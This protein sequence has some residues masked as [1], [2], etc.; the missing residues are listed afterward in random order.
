[1]LDRIEFLLS[2]AIISLRRNRGMTFASIVASALALVIVGG[3]TLTYV[4]LSKYV[5]EQVSKFEMKVFARQDATPDQVTNL[6]N[7]IKKLEGV[8]GVSFK[9]KAE[10]WAEWKKEEPAITAGL[11]LD[12]PMPDTYTVTFKNLEKVNEVKGLVSNMPEVAPNDGVQLS[13]EV[14]DFLQEVMASLRW[15]GLALGIVTLIT[16][17]ILIYNTIRLTMNSRRKELRI[18]ELVGAAKSTVRIPL[19]IEG[20]THGVLGALC[21][22]LILWIGHGVILKVMS[23]IPFSKVAPF[24]LFATMFSLALAGAIY[25]YICSNLAIRENPK[26]ATPR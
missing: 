6:G 12:N 16:G 22:T 7:Q 26:E 10:V 1:M 3:F 19:L 25:G 17:G 2:E 18:M 24:P 23:G 5:N 21:A 13:G 4:G 15:L 14:Q 11:E 20:I 8:N 9:S